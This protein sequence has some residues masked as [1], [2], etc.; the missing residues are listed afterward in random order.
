M[1]IAAIERTQLI[2]LVVYWPQVTRG[3][4]VG[5]E[6]EEVWRDAGLD[7]FSQE[8]M[9]V[10]R[11][12]AQQVRC[13]CLPHVFSCVAVALPALA[14]GSAAGL[15]FTRSWGS[16]VWALACA[17]LVVFAVPGRVFAV[18]NVSTVA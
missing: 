4:A 9:A 14:C 5:M 12:L 6:P 13:L 17:L 7:T 18:P 8:D 2:I 3:W 16:V 11:L 1:I 15:L 10:A